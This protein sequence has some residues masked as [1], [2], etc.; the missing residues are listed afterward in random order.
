[1]S[2]ARLNETVYERRQD[3]QSLL[4]ALKGLLFATTLSLHKSRLIIPRILRLLRSRDH[5][6]SDQILAYVRANTEQMPTWIWIFWAP[7]LLVMLQ[8]DHATMEHQMGRHLLFKLVKV[9]PQAAYYPLR[10]KFTFQRHD[11]TEVLRELLKQ[12]KIRNPHVLHDIEMIGKELGDNV[13]PR[14]EEGL[15]AWL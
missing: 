12:L 4:N 13:K 1:M 15:C 2:Y 5:Q 10:A 6:A 14:P 7:Q 11:P 8:Q 3:M 9:Y